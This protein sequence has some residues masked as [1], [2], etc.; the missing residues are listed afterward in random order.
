M[1]HIAKIIGATALVGC[2]ATGVSAQSS[3]EPPKP[4]MSAASQ[5]GGS[6]YV[7]YVAAW[8]QALTEQFD[9]LSI[10]Q[11][12]GGSSQNII[13]VS[14][15]DT[16]FG[17]TASSQAYIGYYGLG[18]AEGEKYQ[19]FVGLHPAYPTYMTVL[20]LADSGIDSFEDLAGAELAVGVPGGG[21]DVISRE[22]MGYLGIEPARYV[23]ASW[24]DTGGLLRDGLADA[25][26][27]IAGHPA[28]FLQELEVSHE[29]NFLE[30][31]SE[32]IDGFLEEYPYYAP[33]ALAAG[34]YEGMEEEFNTVGQMNFMIGS[35]EL[36]D[37]FVTALLDTIYASAD[38]LA[39]A[40][41]DFAETKLENVRGIP[42]PLHP[43]AKRYYEERDVE[44]RQ[45]PAPAE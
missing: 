3:V 12:P 1:N 4:V 27:Y 21:S 7:T 36:P 41:P 17:I 18:W 44:I 11:E 34:T 25:V 39:Q 9:G 45:A 35:P 37:D 22:L 16:D 32:Q 15:G 20:T 2:A 28:G 24:E 8:I 13:L 29:L 23:N 42:V 10:T 14:N 31:N 6:L 26:L 43:A 38:Q 5:V 40:H 30:L 19:N 33:V